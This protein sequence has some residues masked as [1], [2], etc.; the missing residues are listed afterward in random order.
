MNEVRRE[1]QPPPILGTIVFWD[2]ERHFGRIKPIGGGPE[3]F[4]SRRKLSKELEGTLFAR[5]LIGRTVSFAIEHHPKGKRA[6][7]VTAQ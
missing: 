2:Y 4:L 5:K 1:P 7:N 6:V 3:V